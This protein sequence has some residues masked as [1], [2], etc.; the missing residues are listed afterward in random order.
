MRLSEWRKAAPSKEAGGPK[1]GALVDPVLAALGAD[2]DPHGWVAWGD[3]PGVRY[4]ILVPTAAGLITC[5]VRVNVP[6]EGARVSA[7]L[8]RW[9]RVQS[10]ELAVET[11]AGH[12]LVSF[13]VEGNVLQGADETADR[14]AGFALEVFAA[15]DGRPRPEP[16]PSARRRAAGPRTTTTATPRAA[17][18]RRSTTGSSR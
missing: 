15:V 8:V 16:R 14:I 7:K 6:S 3:E 13:Q 9:N 5:F 17:A 11:S 12:R 2:D 4:T 18:A 10:G 1:V